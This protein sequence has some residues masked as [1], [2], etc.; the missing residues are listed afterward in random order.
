MAW[1]DN[2]Y[3]TESGGL[4]LL[5]WKLHMQEL[6]EQLTLDLSIDGSLFTEMVKAYLFLG[7]K[8][9]LKHSV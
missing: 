8:L 2:E 7:E 4:Y 1:F 5:Q 6:I 9:S 3:L